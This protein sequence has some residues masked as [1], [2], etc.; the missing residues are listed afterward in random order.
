MHEFALSVFFDQFSSVPFIVMCVVDSSCDSA[1]IIYST[2]LSPNDR[3]V[4]NI[5]RI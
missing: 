4:L 3:K 5:L 2:Q 1:I